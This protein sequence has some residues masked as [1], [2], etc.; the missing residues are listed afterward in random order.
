LQVG[1]LNTSTTFSGVIAGGNAGTNI[2]LTKV[3]SGTL[4]L[5]GANLYTG[6]TTINGGTLTVD[7]A[8]SLAST[9]ITANAGAT[10]NVNGA[11]PASAAVTAIGAVNFAGNAGTG[12]FT[13]NLAV[14]NIGN[15]GAAAVQPS[16]WPATP[17]VL[18]APV[19]ITGTGSLDLTNNELIT[20]D[21]LANVATRIASGQITTS[22]TGGGLGS[23][24]LGGGQVEVRF[25]LLGDTNLD[26]KVDVTDL[27]NLASSYGTGSGALWVQ[28]DT[29]YDGKVDVTDLGNLAS[30]Y[31]GALA[32]GPSGGASAMVAQSLAIPAGDAT[33]VP[34][35]AAIGFV[36]LASL[37]MTRRRRRAS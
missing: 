26:G 22:S 4:T 7:A 27:G 29:N 20:N 18:N 1:S 21:T 11:I 5:S 13:R 14:L 3:G 24:D 34:E 35:P 30:S 8:G 17:A 23:L 19:G 37:T 6:A 32:S 9:S 2:S 28:G 25:T 12:S 10:L 31:G 33:S 36:A 16:T 15:G